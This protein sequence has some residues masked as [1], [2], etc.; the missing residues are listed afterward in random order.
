MNRYRS[1][2]APRPKPR[3]LCFAR[4]FAGATTSIPAASRAARRA[5]PAIRRRVP[6]SGSAACAKSPRVK[7]AACPQ[8]RFLPVTDDVV[9]WHLAGRDDDGRDFVMGV[10]PMLQDETCFF[11]AAD[12]DKTHWQEDAAAFLE[13]CRRMNLTGCPGAI[14]LRQRRAR[15]ALLRG[16]HSRRL[17]P[18]ARFAHPHR[19]HGTP[20]G[21]R[22]GF[23][24][25]LLPQSRHAAPGRLRQPDRLAAAKATAGTWQ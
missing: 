5:S 3:S 13:T 2:I 4:S 18:Q 22:P 24:R 7:C 9:R 21:Y 1:I 16:G 15:L 6:T 10:Y 25:P 11:L 8:R 17:G 23:L 20:A 19:D 12:F 14:A